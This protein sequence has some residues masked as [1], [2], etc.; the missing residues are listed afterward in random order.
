MYKNP[1][2]FIQFELW[3]DCSIGCKFC[4][5]KG[6]PKIDKKELYE[7]WKDK[8]ICL[9]ISD[10]EGRSRTIAEAMAN[11]A[12]PIVTRTSGVNDDIYNNENGLIVSIGDYIEMADCIEKMEKNRK[13]L[14]IMGEKAH[15]EIENKSSMD[16]HYRFWKDIIS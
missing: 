5:N 6:Q 16:D 7:F 12:V 8:D 1:N 3:K 2:K 4:C 15:L 13:L 9:N 10:F 14:P 11:G